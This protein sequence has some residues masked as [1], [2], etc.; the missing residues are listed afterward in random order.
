MEAS[1]EKH[2]SIG[3]DNIV[4]ASRKTNCSIN[5]KRIRNRR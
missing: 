2:D 5:L 1:L 4:V 3:L